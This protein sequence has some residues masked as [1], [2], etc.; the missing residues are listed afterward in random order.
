MTMK[1]NVIIFLSVLISFWHTYQSLSQSNS[2]ADPT[3][4][5]NQLHQEIAQKSSEPSCNYLKSIG[6]DSLI[7]VIKKDTALGIDMGYYLLPEGWGST[8]EGLK[9][10]D[11]TLVRDHPMISKAQTFSSFEC[12]GTEKLDAQH[13]LN[14]YYKEQILAEMAKT[15]VEVQD[16]S[17]DETINQQYQKNFQVLFPCSA[18]PVH[19]ETRLVEHSESNGQKGLTMFHFMVFRPVYGYGFV[20]HYTKHELSAKPE[21]FERDKKNYLYAVAHAEYTPEYISKCHQIQRAN[22]QDIWYQYNQQ[23]VNNEFWH[24]RDYDYDP[25][26]RKEFRPWRRH[27][28]G[29]HADYIDQLDST[30]LSNDDPLYDPKNW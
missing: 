10:P 3:R 28:C 14:E 26:K 16:F 17:T 11:G 25:Y 24:Y 19:F 2:T 21:N 9:G 23:L 13:V 29:E 5:I 27:H 18:M 12:Q 8:S 1:A 22:P 30:Y 7:K 20:L 6:H 4:I 15:K